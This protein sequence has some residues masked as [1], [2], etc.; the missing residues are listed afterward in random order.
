MKFRILAIF[1]K[2]FLNSRYMQMSLPHNFSIILFTKMTKIQYFI[3]KDEKV[4]LLALYIHT[5]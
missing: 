5:E 1:M 2:H 4:K 3:Y